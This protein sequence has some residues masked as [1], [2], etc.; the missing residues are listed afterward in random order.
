MRE[1]HFAIALLSAAGSVQVIAAYPLAAVGALPSILAL[2]RAVHDG[3]LCS[4]AAVALQRAVPA[5]E[6][7]GALLLAPVASKS[8][9]ANALAGHFIAAGT[10]VA[11]AAQGA[12]G[13]PRTFR[14][15]V[16]AHVASPTI[17]AETRSCYRIARAA[18]LAT[19][20]I[21]AVL[22]VETFGARFIAPGAC[23]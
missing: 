1:I 23:L 3:A 12:V 11:I 20:L 9:G 22:T 15:R 21:A 4:V 8:S 7:D 5:V 10:V 18:V 6:T 16:G 17:R 2:A 13:A 14:A 19:A